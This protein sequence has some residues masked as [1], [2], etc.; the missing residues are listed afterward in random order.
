MRDLRYD[1]IDSLRAFAALSVFGFHLL[2]QPGFTPPDWLIPYTANLNV[3][4]SVFFVISG[5]VIY[6]PFVRARFHGEPVP[7]LRGFA[8]RRTARIVPAYWVALALIALW[9]GLDYVFTPSGIVTYFGFL[10]VYD[11]DTTVNG[12]GQAWSLCIEVTFYIGI[13]VLA[14]LWRARSV[15]G[16]LALAGALVLV[17]VLW[18]LAPFYDVPT[19]GQLPEPAT[20]TLPA[21]ADELAFG[22]LLAALTV[23]RPLRVPGWSGWVLAAV[24]FAGA[25]VLTDTGASESQAGNLAH[26]L[27]F[28]LVGVGLV[29]PAIAGAPRWL[30]HPALRW[31]GFVSYGFYLWHLAVLRELTDAGWRGKVGAL[32]YLAVALALSVGLAAA[33]WYAIERPALRLA[34]RARW[35]TPRTPAR[36]GALR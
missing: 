36:E 24:A 15:R 21:Y 3:G 25:G 12:I 23:V 16:E 19:F 22:M 35:A 26:H 31:A 34:R 33:S 11:P 7:P 6:R 20:L 14:V 5:F 13:A 28:G 2:L 29:L 18:R 27:L 4:V 8:V 9:L 30:L 10:Q 17:T 32:G 1:G